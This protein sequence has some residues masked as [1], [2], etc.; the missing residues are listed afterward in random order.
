MLLAIERWVWAPWFQ[1][2]TLLYTWHS[3]IRGSAEATAGLAITLTAFILIGRL[4]SR[5]RF[6]RVNR[7]LFGTGCS[8]H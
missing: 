4:A 8:R 3:A 1:P 5:M 6:V 2:P 7:H